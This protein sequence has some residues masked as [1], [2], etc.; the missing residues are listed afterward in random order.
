MESFVLYDLT[1]KAMTAAGVLQFVQLL[2]SDGAGLKSGHKPGGNI[3]ANHKSFHFRSVRTVANM[4]E[5]IA[6]FILFAVGGILAGA[7]PEHLGLFA[8]GYVGARAIYVL[9]YWFNF[10][11]S[12][13]VI[14][15]VSLLMLL[16]MGITLVRSLLG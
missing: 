3:E 4:N 8:V 1:I 9:C 7:N 15:G 14:F 16:G 10:K 12:R 2:V 13:S 11:L 6:I 5:S